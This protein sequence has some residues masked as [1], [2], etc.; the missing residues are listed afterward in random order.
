MARE[1]ARPRAARVGS[2]AWA[3]RAGGAARAPAARRTARAFGR[4]RPAERGR[5]GDPPRLAAYTVMR[6]VADG[7]YANLELPGELRRRRLRGRDA[8]FATELTYGATRM[9]GVYDRIIA[10]AADRP[11]TRIDGGV[12]DTL[13][14]GLHQ[15]LSMRV[16]PARRRRRE[17]R[18]G[19]PGRRRRRGR[20]R[21]C[22]VRRVTEADLATWLTRIIPS[23]ADVTTALAIERLHPSGSPR[24]WQAL[25]GHDRATPQTVDAELAALLAADN[26][27][28]EVTLVAPSGVSDARR[29]RAPERASIPMCRRPCYWQSGDP[30]GLAAVRTGRAAVQRP[31]PGR[32]PGARGAPGATPREADRAG[33]NAGSTCAPG[34]AARPGC[35]P[36]WRS[37]AA[38]TWSPNEIAPHRARS[39]PR[40]SSRRWSAR[41]PRVSTWRCA[42]ATASCR[43][44]G[45]RGIRPGVD[46]RPVH[47][48]SV[49]CGG[50]R[51]RG[52]DAPRPI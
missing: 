17:R 52:G 26:S 23:D 27:P 28:G 45:A 1:A 12:L 34:R 24:P 3:G 2:S 38:P 18:P 6:A 15:V 9:R 49:R 46:R 37:S 36:R 42:P 22:G 16:P 40:P 7:G 29:S 32:R 4:D 35:W 43:G 11:I 13:R 8:A 48:A 44:G 21:E 14:L 51:R 50:G 47:R 5:A 19:P 33:A 25:L 10:I 20:A 39:S 31:L 41:R 30:G